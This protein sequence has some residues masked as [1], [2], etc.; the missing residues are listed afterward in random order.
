MAEQIHKSDITFSNEEK[1]QKRIKL[2]KACLK[3]LE[4]AK[5]ATDLQ[6]PNCVSVKVDPKFEKAI[7]DDIKMLEEIEI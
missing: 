7:R 3:N 4:K 2:A 1:K 6:L 5:N